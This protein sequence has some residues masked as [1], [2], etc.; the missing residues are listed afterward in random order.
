MMRLSKDCGLMLLALF[1]VV[2][3][4]WVKPME[5]RADTYS[6]GGWGIVAAGAAVAAT[7][8][9][10]IPVAVE[11]IAASTAGSAA[12]WTVVGAAAADVTAAVVP[13]I[14]YL[15]VGTFALSSALLAYGLYQGWIASG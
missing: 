7:G 12:A 3:G 14:P 13:L 15:A 4:I 9:Y 6:I 2:G 10:A 1:L 5:S 11:A 8:G